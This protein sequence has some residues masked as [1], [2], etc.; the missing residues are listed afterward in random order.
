MIKIVLVD[1]HQ[2]FLDGMI[3]V[4]SGQ[5]NMEILFVENSAKNA[6]QKIKKQVPDIVITDISMPDMN[7]LEF[8]KIL[9]KQYPEIKILVLSM[10]ENIQ[11]SEDIDGYLLKET[12]KN[13]LLQ[14]I[15]GIV[16]NDEKHFVSENKKNSLDFNKSILSPREK[17][18]IKLIAQEYTTEQIAEKLF[19]SKN[20][21]ETHRKNIFYKLDV[22]N[23]AG[24]VKK[25]IHLGIVK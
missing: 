24:L 4:L 11:S 25:A 9:K 8:I 1:D 22:K 7:G 23:I 12:D 3:A 16:L 15:N 6:V 5:D 19:I 10:F 21:I 18:I 20:T 14:A 2:M 17:D 13:T